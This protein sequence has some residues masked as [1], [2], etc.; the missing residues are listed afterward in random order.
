MGCISVATKEELMWSRVAL[1]GAVLAFPT[2]AARAADD[3]SVLIKAPPQAT[4]IGTSKIDEIRAFPE[5]SGKQGKDKPA[6]ERIVDVTG[7][8][9]LFQ[10]DR[11]FADT[12]SFFDQQFKQ[13]SYQVMARVETPSATAWTLKR[14]DG[15]VANCVVRNTSPATIE[16]AEAAATAA[17]VLPSR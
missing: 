2:A 11:S 9:R 12:V 7:V 3:S 1:L 5:M 15:T 13:A 8:D 4:L 17:T 14:P 6:L 16:I 10:S